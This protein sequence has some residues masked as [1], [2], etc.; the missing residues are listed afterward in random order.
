MYMHYIDSILCKIYF[1]SAMRR[2]SSILR[3]I[4]Q[5][6]HCNVRISFIVMIIF[7]MFVLLKD[8]FIRAPLV[9][10]NDLFTDYNNLFQ[11][12]GNNDNYSNNIFNSTNVTSSGSSFFMSLSYFEQLTCATRNL[13]SAG[14]VAQNL[15]AKVVMPFLLRSRL[16]G[17]PDLLPD[18]EVPDVFF[19][20]HTVYDI[21][22]LNTTFHFLSNTYLVDFDNFLYN[23]PR[24][25]VVVDFIHTRV[26]PKELSLSP[27]SIAQINH[28][29]IFYSHN[30][31]DCTSIVFRHKQSLLEKLKLM[32][33]ISTRHLGV[34]EFV[35]HK[36]ICINPLV[37]VTTDEL[38]KVIGPGLHTVV[39]TQW[40]GC[41]YHSCDITARRNISS[42]FRNRFLYRS[43]H[44]KSKP[45]VKDVVL[46]LSSTIKITATQYL[47]KI[48]L[49]SPFISVHIRIE[50]LS[51]VNDKINGH[52]VCCLG[53]LDS[54]L[55]SLKWKYFNRTLLITDIAEYGSDA[56]YDKVCLPHSRKVK[57]I[58]KTMGLTQHSFKPNVVG[59]SKNSGFAS[60]VEMHMLSMGDRLVVM[61]QGSFKHQIITN[62]LNSNPA[63]K[64]YHICT[65][66]GNVLNEFS[67]LNRDCWKDNG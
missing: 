13:L 3:A 21:A 25:I 20:L 47:Q 10:N 36:Y 6:S 43:N 64:L 12:Q 35:I 11:F 53:I 58:L 61:G 54:L 56:C 32:L 62:F 18:K 63:N 52:S 55:K 67:K 51:R 5:Y 24:E 26:A 8:L 30:I 38:K 23:G 31:F 45:H 1:Y 44:T 42:S 49:S 57:G 2:R 50:K 17:I 40:R 27:K 15:G 46:P 4:K 66:D 7:A 29:M 37:D 41:A 60:L 19:P 59:S 65:E 48:N 33:R 14:N 28:M 34:K 39:F 9:I 16:Y 22:Q